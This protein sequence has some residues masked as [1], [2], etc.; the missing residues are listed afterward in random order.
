MKKEVL[1]YREYYKFKETY[2]ITFRVELFSY[3]QDILDD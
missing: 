2:I 3:F 1:H